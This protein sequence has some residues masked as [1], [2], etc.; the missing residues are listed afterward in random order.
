MFK[1][2][3]KKAIAIIL[4]LAM[5]AEVGTP[6]AYAAG[7]D[8][9]SSSEAPEVQIFDDGSGVV[10]DKDTADLIN[11]AGQYEALK[12]SDDTVIA[13]SVKRREEYTKGYRLKDGSDAVL[14][15]PFSVNEKD[16]EDK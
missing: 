3:F 6:L 1:R 16:A 11:S 10:Y 5:L 7:L 4:I 12:A 9:G 14:L 13:E 8:A 2:L 15:Y